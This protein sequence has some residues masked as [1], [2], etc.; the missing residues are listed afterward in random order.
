MP[1]DTEF[2]KL[3]QK[4]QKQVLLELN[5]EYWKRTN[6]SYFNELYCLCGKRSGDYFEICFKLFGQH[7]SK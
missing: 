7:F 2:I 5:K 3:N 6:A 1:I 4:N